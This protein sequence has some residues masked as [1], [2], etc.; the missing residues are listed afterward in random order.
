MSNSSMRRIQKECREVV[1]DGE[2]SDLGITIEVLDEASFTHI[3]AEVRGPPD[4]PY[5]NGRFKLDIKFP[6]NY[7]FKP[8]SAKFLTKVWHPN[9]SSQTGTI[10]LDILKDKW[11]A[12]YSLRV[13][14]LSI[15][16]L[17]SSAEPTD[18]Q[19]AVVAKQY[20]AERAEFDRTARFWTQHFAEGPG[21][22]DEEMTAR[23]R[24][25]V[26]KTHNEQIEAIS[27][28]SCNDWNVSKALSYIKS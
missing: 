15:Q 2:M 24:N 17:L 27:V 22:K 3:K 8:L 7:P 13:V 4:T 5:E 12:T 21:E 6:E 18:P 20:M 19:D 23:V 10:C 26:S 14:L 16:N 11:T 28:L 9:V 25:V 1:T